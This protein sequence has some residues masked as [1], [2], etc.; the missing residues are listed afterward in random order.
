VIQPTKPHLHKICEDSIDYCLLNAASCP[1]KIPS[2]TFPEHSVHVKKSDNCE[3]KGY[4]LLVWNFLWYLVA[5]S[6]PAVARSTENPCSESYFCC[7]GPY[8]LLLD[9]LSDRWHLLVIRKAEGHN[10]IFLLSFNWSLLPRLTS[11]VRW[12]AKI[13]YTWEATGWPYLLFCP[14][15]HCFFLTCYWIM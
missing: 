8:Q 11:F 12:R 2:D 3:L 13:Y 10:T 4:Q 7:C 15:R 1:P 9:Q 6:K 14:S 5:L